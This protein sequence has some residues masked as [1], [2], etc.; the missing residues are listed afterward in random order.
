MCVDPP[1]SAPLPLTRPSI[2][3]FT[4]HPPCAGTVPG[5][6]NTAENQ[7]DKVPGLPG[8][9]VLRGAEEKQDG[10]KRFA[11]NQAGV[12]VLGSYGGAGG[13]APAL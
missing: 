11:E 13:E 7:A 8:A 12:S 5:T 1:V 10:S 9:Q 6:E 2:R 3:P 4:E